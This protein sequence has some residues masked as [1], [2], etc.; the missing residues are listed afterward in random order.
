MIS[1]WYEKDDMFYTT[2]K[3][4]DFFHEMMMELKSIG[5]DF[6]GDVSLNPVAGGS[7]ILE[8]RVQRIVEAP[9]EPEPAKHVCGKQGFGQEFSDVCPACEED[10]KDT[11]RMLDAKDDN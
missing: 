1:N 3:A 4:R 6:V 11:K 10:K 5:W 7:M 2:E 8:G 9:K